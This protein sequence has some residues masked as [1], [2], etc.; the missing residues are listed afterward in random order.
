M[1]STNSHKASA[2]RV[3]G[4]TI[5]LF[6]ATILYQTERRRPALWPSHPLLLSVN[7]TK[8]SCLAQRALVGALPDGG[9]DDS[10]ADRGQRQHDEC[11]DAIFIGRRLVTAVLGV[12]GSPVLPAKD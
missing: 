7:S 9:D 12:H 2:G 11:K 3:A 6:D 1:R 8:P 5:V 10:T 4:A